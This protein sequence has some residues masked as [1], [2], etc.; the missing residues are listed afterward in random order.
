MQL[1]VKGPA[2]SSSLFL[3]SV[4]NQA[5]FADEIVQNAFEGRVH[6]S[7]RIL[8]AFLVGFVHV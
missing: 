6:I 3:Q 1:G 5:Y 4:K 7:L 2:S 8:K